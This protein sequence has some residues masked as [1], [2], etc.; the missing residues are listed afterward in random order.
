MALPSK[1]IQIN[2]S[3]T[4]NKD[5][6]YCYAKD[7]KEEY[8]ED[9]DLENF[10][11]I[12]DWLKKNNIDSLNLAG[13]EP[14]IHPEIGNMLELANK[15]K[16]KI[17]VF[18]NGL[19]NESFLKYADHANFFLV[20]YNHK[21]TYT[22]KEYE[23]LH[24]NL[25]YIKQ[26]GKG[27]TLAFNITN[28][29]SSCD[30]IIEAAKRYNISNVNMDLVIPN[31]LKNNE[32]IPPDEFRNKKGM[33]MGFFNKLKENNISVKIT[34][35]LPFC[36]FKE[37]IKSSKGALYS[38]CN[39]GYGI[40][41]INPD[42]SIFPCLSIFF[43]GPSLTS[44]NTF[45]EISE[46]YNTSISDLKWKRYIYPEC[47]SCIYLLRKKCQGSC[48]CHK[49]SPFE[50]LRTQRY[51]IFSQYTIEKMKGFI[52]QIENSMDSLDIL[53]PKPKRKIKIYLF[54]NKNDLTYYSGAYYYPP[55]VGG[56]VNRNIYYQYTPENSSNFKN[57]THELAHI[58]IRQENNTNNLPMW[59]E[60]GFCNYANRPNKSFPELCN[61]L[62]DL[63]KE[64]KLTP[65]EDMSN[66]SLLKYD[67]AP[68]DRNIAYVQSQSMVVYIIDKFGMDSVKKIL[69]D[70]YDNFNQHFEEVIEHKFSEINEEWFAI[71]QKHE[72]IV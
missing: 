33:L 2:V 36:V 49:C 61:E 1:L 22:E 31:S 5:C 30:Y 21:D 23:L 67:N 40:V 13:G 50:T 69:F 60:E 42:L 38:R 58:Y 47:K 66:T 3:Y 34:R 20:N 25:D 14:T 64:K 65:F 56:F 7:L 43:K 11:K 41:A 52:S 48:L 17:T 45:K 10:K 71:L 12:L 26:R 62:I 54:N 19:F 28:E 46:F 63:M 44:F 51:T 53:L 32:Y 15:E 57:V 29:I 72:L 68:L 27:I 18:T 39:V 55:W 70:R 59:F 8:R 6:S 9:M 24:K 16:F 37:E 35:P 4:C